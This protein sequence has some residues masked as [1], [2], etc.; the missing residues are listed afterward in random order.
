METGEWLNASA[1]PTAM[2]L[3][4]YLKGVHNES[5]KTKENCLFLDSSHKGAYHLLRGPYWIATA[6]EP[7]CYGTDRLNI[8]KL[9]PF[10]A[11][12]LGFWGF[13]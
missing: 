5:H 8:T 7:E 13:F 1:Y 9:S 2:I 3:Y 11:H 4:V 10:W 12:F 6:D